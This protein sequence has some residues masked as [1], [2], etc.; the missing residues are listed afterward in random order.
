MA[1]QA[2]AQLG[3]DSAG[4]VAQ[5]TSARELHKRTEYGD[6]RHS[7]GDP[8]ERRIAA[9]DQ[10]LVDDHLKLQRRRQ[11]KQLDDEGCQ[12]NLRQRPVVAINRWPELP[13]VKSRLVLTGSPQRRVM[14]TIV[15]DQTASN[16]ASFTS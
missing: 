6:R 16:S 13:E 3:I 4:R 12:K 9:V 15:R 5:G 1:E 2:A 7:V 14:R 10:N 8:W 11:G